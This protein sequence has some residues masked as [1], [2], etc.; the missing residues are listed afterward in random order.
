MPPQR[1]SSAPPRPE[2]AGRPRY[3]CCACPVDTRRWVSID[4]RSA[5][6]AQIYEIGR[7]RNATLGI[8]EEQGRLLVHGSEVGVGVSPSSHLVKH[9]E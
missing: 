4:A 5:R 2:P 7:L 6:S 3:A 9:A 1:V 8:A